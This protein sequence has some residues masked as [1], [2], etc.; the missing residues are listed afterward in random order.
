MNKDFSSNWDDKNNPSYANSSSNSMGS[1]GSS[2]SSGSSGKSMGSSSNSTMG[3]SG[4]SG[5][6]DSA[7]TSIHCTVANCANHCQ[8]QQ[9]CS[10]NTV[11]IGTHEANPTQD[12]C[13]DCQSFRLS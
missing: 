9:Y 3:S 11:Q 5:K 6:T 4:S 8:N 7:N 2:S 10:L 12:K 1:S 13:V